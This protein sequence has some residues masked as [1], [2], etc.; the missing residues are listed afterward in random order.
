MSF[1]KKVG[2]LS[3]IYLV[4][5]APFVLIFSHQDSPPNSVTCLAQHEVTV[6]QVFTFKVSLYNKECGEAQA[7]LGIM[8]AALLAKPP[9]Y[10]LV[11]VALGTWRLKYPRIGQ[12]M[13]QVASEVAANP[14]ASSDWERVLTIPP[15][16]NR[17]QAKPPQ[18]D[19][20]VAKPK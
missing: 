16:L 17:Q 7:T 15:D 10:A 3:I 6:L 1:A 18:G 2:W 13:S 5:A 20:S 9:N 11:A 8:N 19:G 4:V 12:L 14:Q